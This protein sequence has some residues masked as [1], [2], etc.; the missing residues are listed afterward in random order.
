MAEGLLRRVEAQGMPREDALRMLGL[1]D[2][3]ELIALAAGA[4][5]PQE[6]RTVLAQRAEALGITARA[7]AAAVGRGK[8]AFSDEAL[9][10]LRV[11]DADDLRNL[12]R[13]TRPLPTAVEKRLL[14]DAVD[15]VST[16]LL[17]DPD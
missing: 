5:T 7:E 2:E 3:D 9:E 14:Q 10:D 13:G 8:G 12:A 6:L 11:M 4:R 17:F 1:R 16:R 15:D